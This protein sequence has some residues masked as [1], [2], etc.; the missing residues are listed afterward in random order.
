MK[1][2]AV[3]IPLCLLLINGTIFLWAV[4]KANIGPS[5]ALSKEQWQE[6]LQ[7]LA[8][9]LPRRHKNAFHTV[10][11]EQFERAVA[12]LSAAI[13]SLQDH[14]IQVGLMRIVAMVGDA[15]TELSGFGGTF[16]RFP[17]NLYWF[18]S[19]LRVVR[20]TAGYKR[21]LGARVVQI[22]EVSINDA[23]GRIDQLVAHENEYW[24]RLLSAGFMPYAEILHALKIVPDL[25]RGRW[26]FEDREGRFSLDIDTIYPNDKVEW[27]DA[28][29]EFPLYRQRPGEQFWF[30]YLEG[31]QTVYVNFRGY[32]DSFSK[33]AEELLNFVNGHPIKRLVIDVRQNRGGD[34]TKVR[35]QLLPGLKQVT[36]L[37]QPGA[38]FVITGR[39][40]QSAAVV[41]ALDF[42]KEMKAILVGEPTGG[43]PNGYSEHG[44]FKLPNSG[45]TVS[46]SS[47]YYKFQDEDTPAVMPDK[48]IEP[49][50]EAYQAG[51]D[52]VME[53]ILVS[54]SS[55]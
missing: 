40:T 9:E 15:H 22:G 50:W 28:S 44:E 37:R 55:K 30:T 18:G 19:E 2:L 53:W 29:K 25:S 1:R 23:A 33:Q 17:L 21:A 26:T 49:A 24:V 43:R 39:A 16:R 46:Y 35:G 20:T 5:P 41:N 42:R 8:K 4:P 52:P 51:R 13:P 48:V 47:R 3:S 7:Y 45:L 11:R 6:D 31:A 54:P 32:R 10:S 34:F 12:E 38:F 36:V 14:E 27:L